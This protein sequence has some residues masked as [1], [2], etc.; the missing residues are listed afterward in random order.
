M[1]TLLRE[2]GQ[3]R[4]RFGFIA[5]EMEVWAVYKHNYNLILYRC[6]FN[7]PRVSGSFG[8]KKRGGIIAR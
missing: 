8:A 2:L 3:L 7:E 1:C 6:A 4:I 5:V